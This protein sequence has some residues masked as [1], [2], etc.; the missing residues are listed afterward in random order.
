MDAGGILDPM[1]STR[2]PPEGGIF[3]NHDPLTRS[4]TSDMT[5]FF[6][7]LVVFSP[8]LGA[9]QERGGGKERKDKAAA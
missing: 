8:I 9:E 2:D 5:H 4:A 1:Y 3:L 6:L 7:V